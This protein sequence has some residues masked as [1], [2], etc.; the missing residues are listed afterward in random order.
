MFNLSNLVFIDASQITLLVVIAALLVLY[1]IFMFIRNK[2]EKEK[3]TELYESIHKGDYVL[4]YSGIMGKVVEILEKQ[5]GKFLTIQTGEGK[6]SG[7]VCVTIDAVYT[8]T[9]NKDKI[10]GIDGE[11]ISSDS[12]DQKV[13]SKQEENN[14]EKKVDND[15]K[16]QN[17]TEIQNQEAVV[18]TQNNNKATKKTSKK[19]NTKKA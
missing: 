3:R 16:V 7:F 18:S 19:Q 4:T 15:E 17:Q 2:K 9:D 13:E 8:F 1:P 5:N 11:P 12:K 6:N 10:F 14:G